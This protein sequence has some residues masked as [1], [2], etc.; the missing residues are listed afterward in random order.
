MQWGDEEVV[1]TRRRANPDT[2][3]RFDTETGEVATL[4][5]LSMSEEDNYDPETESWKPFVRV[6]GSTSAPL[7]H[8]DTIRVYH[9]DNPG[10]GW[11]DMQLVVMYD[12]EGTEGLFHGYGSLIMLGDMRHVLE[13]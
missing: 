2:P 1:V 13:D 6:N 8:R 12:T 3:Y 7:K 4:V 9:V 5:A 11:V 10:A